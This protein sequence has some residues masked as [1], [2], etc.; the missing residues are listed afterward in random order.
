MQ[1][2]LAGGVTGVSPVARAASFDRRDRT[3]DVIPGREES[4]SL[5]S[6]GKFPHFGA[7]SARFS[8]AFHQLATC[9]PTHKFRIIMDKS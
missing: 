7:I 5:A 8:T 4:F 9:I 1:L 6:S 3:F 2:N